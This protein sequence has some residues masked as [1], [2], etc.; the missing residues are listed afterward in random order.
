MSL[1]ARCIGEYAQVVGFGLHDSR[2]LGLVYEGEA[3]RL[4]VRLRREDGRG[5]IVSRQGVGA[6]G[7]VGFRN[8][9]IVSDLLV[10]DVADARLDLAL[11]RMAWRVVFGNDIPV[12][13]LPKAVGSIVK[14]RELRHL[15]LLDCS[16]GGSL[17]ALCRDID[18]ELGLEAR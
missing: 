1:P 7:L 17:A 16:Y 6:Q 9:A 18:I 5:A 4:V 15:V 2:L 3:G 12:E 14:E 13:D 8:G 11:P 10:W